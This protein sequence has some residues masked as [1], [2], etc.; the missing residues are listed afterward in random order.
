M[1]KLK[2]ILE[3]EI[4]LQ[5][6][7]LETSVVLGFTFDIE[8]DE[9]NEFDEGELFKTFFENKCHEA[10]INVVTKL[11]SDIKRDY[12]ELE[13][14]EVTETFKEDLDDLRRRSIST[15]HQLKE[16]VIEEAK[17]KYSIHR[18][19]SALQDKCSCLEQMLSMVLGN[20]NLTFE[21]QNIE[22][23]ITETNRFY[24]NFDEKFD[25]LKTILSE[26]SRLR[27]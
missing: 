7:I 10:E 21:N 22:A 20:S 26:N 8:N 11:L 14:G 2:N 17:N 27:L 16:D 4:S 25:N 5:Q 1:S 18:K 3:T 12:E 6:Q 24:K 19:K 23:I 13:S 9:A 15:S